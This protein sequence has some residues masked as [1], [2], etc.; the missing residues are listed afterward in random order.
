MAA[1]EGDLNVELGARLNKLERGLKKAERSFNQYSKDIQS[2]SKKTAG[3]MESAFTSSLTRIGGAMA[4]AFTVNAIA[5]F[6]KE[7][8]ELAAKAEGIEAAFKKL[9]QPGLLSNLRAATRGTVTDLELMRQ[10][11]RAQNF[12]VPLEKLATFFEF[13][14]KRSAQTGE[15]VDYLVNSII[16]GI[17][18]KSTLVLDNLGISASRLQEEVKKVGDFGQAAGNIIAEELGKAGD[19]AETTAQK[20]ARQR[21]EIENLK[22]EIGRELI[23]VYVKLLESTKN[24]IDGNNVLGA[25]WKLLMKRINPV[26][27][28]TKKHNEY[29]ELADRVTRAWAKGQELLAQKTNQTTKALKSEKDMMLEI[30][31]AENLASA[32]R[33]SAGPVQGPDYDKMD[34]TIMTEG[35]LL[36]DF[37]DEDLF[38]IENLDEAS[39]SFFEGLQSDLQKSSVL[40]ATLG[41]AFNQAFSEGIENGLDFGDAIKK[42]FQSL[43]KQ[44]I[45]ALLTAIALK[46]V[47]AAL[48]LPTLPVGQMFLAQMGIGGLVNAAS[49]GVAGGGGGLN[50]QVSGKISGSDIL[51]STERSIGRRTRQ[52]GNNGLIG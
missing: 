26:T 43:V 27:E 51:L 37:L 39:K 21:A 29:S 16:D 20:I 5:G 10:A 2:T 7:A 19:V 36:N 45:A 13:A 33:L 35:G 18:R 32:T 50:L 6:A 23:P 40:S 1:T 14:T 34:P 25:S 28:A 30:L 47:L 49:A 11:V 42:M 41:Q 8:V 44:M 52:T 9:N 17:G 31:R 12:Q 48:G 3:S 24:L 15:S 22:L 38:G 46:G 4:A